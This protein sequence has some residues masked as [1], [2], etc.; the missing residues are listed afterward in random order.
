MAGAHRE[1]VSHIAVIAP[2][3]TIA[4]RGSGFHVLVTSASPS[5]HHAAAAGPPLARETPPPA[6]AP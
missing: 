2:Y 4:Y 5:V 3:H 6:R 1:H